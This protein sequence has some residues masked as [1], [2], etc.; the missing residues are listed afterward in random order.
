MFQHCSAESV[1]INPVRHHHRGQRA[2]KVAWLLAQHFEP[3]CLHGTSCCLG[4]AI[5][6]GKDIVQPFLMQH[7]D[8]F[9]E[10]IE[11]IGCRG[12]GES[13]TLVRGKLFVPVPVGPAKAVGFCFVDGALRQR[14]ERQARRQHQ[15]LLRSGHG[16][17]DTPFIMPVVDR[18]K[19]GNRINEKKRAMAGSI[20]RLPHLADP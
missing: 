5:M 2:G 9:G 3:P 11:K 1:G 4:M 8:R 10:T 6:A 15:A 18:G 19:R 13:P 17:I 16:D 20:H 7:V 12:V 14:V